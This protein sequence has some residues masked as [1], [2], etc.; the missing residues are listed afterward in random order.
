M[1]QHI[2]K[3]EQVRKRTIRVR[4]LKGICQIYARCS[5]IECWGKYFS[6]KLK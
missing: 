3:I 4:D 2:Y 5:I 6:E 1:T